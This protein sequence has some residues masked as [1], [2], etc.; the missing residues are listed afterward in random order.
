LQHESVAKAAVDY[1]GLPMTSSPEWTI[2]GSYSH[3]FS[4][5]NGG[6]LEAKVD[7]QYKSDY[8][9]SWRIKDEPYNYQESFFIF[10]ANLTY[11]S[12]DGQWSISAYGRNLTEYAEKRSYFGEPVYQTGIGNPRTYGAVFSAR[13]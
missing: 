9:L 10:N 1:N 3:R 7:G 5:W 4:L 12:P 13:F 6:N 8:K 2:N 11:N